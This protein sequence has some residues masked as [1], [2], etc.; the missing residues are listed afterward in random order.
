MLHAQDP[1]AGSASIRTNTEEHGGLCPPN[2]P[3]FNASDQR[4]QG[5]PLSVVEQKQKTA[6]SFVA[7]RKHGQRCW[8]WDGFNHYKYRPSSASWL[9]QALGSHSCVA[10]P[11]CPGF[12]LITAEGTIILT[13][14]V[15][16]RAK[17]ADTGDQPTRQQA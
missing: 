6:R 10:L 5:T 16:A 7:G 4:Q 17:S 8:G 3:E 12:H 13:P 14:V 15:Q 1:L 9:E 11:S 2:P